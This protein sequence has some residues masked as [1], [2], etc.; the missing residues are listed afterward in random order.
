MTRGCSELTAAIS[1]PRL[2]NSVSLMSAARHSPHF[3]RV[4]RQR[5]GAVNLLDGATQKEEGYL[6][7]TWVLV[8]EYQLG[9][10]DDRFIQGEEFF[11]LRVSRS[12]RSGLGN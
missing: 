9:S 6:H 7:H 12:V 10:F 4:D 2:L 8:D 11:E 1:G 3:G 5:L